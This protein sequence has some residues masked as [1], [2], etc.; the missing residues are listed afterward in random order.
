MKKLIAVIL[1]LAALVTAVFLTFEFSYKLSPDSFVTDRTTFIYSNK[2]MNEE[3]IRKIEKI[4]GINARK[5]KEILKRVK[6]IYIFSQSKVYSNDIKAVGIVDTGIYYPMMILKLKDFFDYQSDDNFY[7][8]KDDYKD[9]LRLS[10][11]EKIYLK[12]HRGLLFIG[13]SKS[14]IDKTIYNSGKQ[15]LKT[16]EIINSRADSDLG[17]FVF[18][19]ERERLF[20]VDRVVLSGNV[21]GDKIL[22][23]GSIY[24]DSDFIRELSVQ[25]ANRRMNKYIDENRLYFS[26][27]DIRMLDTFV[28]RALSSKE[29]SRREVSIIQDLFL[30]GSPSIFS[31]FNGEMV[32]D[33]ENGYYLLGIKTSEDAERYIEYFKN[34]EDINVEKDIL[35]NIYICIGADTFVPVPEPKELTPNQFFSGK[36]DTYYGKVE[37]DG[38]YESDSLRIK[39]Q[40][41][42][43]KKIAEN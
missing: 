12:A 10:E 4:F 16:L 29:Y 18:N 13:S 34:D 8:L 26:T 17:T 9:E 1:S 37:A 33:V 21:E 42:L 35:G 2:N 7:K 43:D 32:V 28:L 39:V 24:G 23:D 19:Q 14:E 5:E 25:P 30:K 15:S 3:K 20:G 40:I 6:S 36:V 41:D 38:F 27:A 11:D 22:L 31:Q